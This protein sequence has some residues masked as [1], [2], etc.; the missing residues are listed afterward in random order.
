M[1]LIPLINRYAI[2]VFFVEGDYSTWPY[3]VAVNL[4]VAA[5]FGI[6]VWG[7][8]RQAGMIEAETS[9]ELRRQAFKNLQKLSY[10][11]FDQTPQGWIMARMTSDARRLSLIISWGLVDFVWA[12]LSMLFIMIVLYITF[13]KLAVIVTLVVPV[14]FVVA[15][16]FR[17]LILKQHRIARKT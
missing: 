11:Y 2:D 10:S 3:F 17:K 5:G 4:F 15:Y 13:F 9:Y 7:F 8:I 1:H 16:F 6:S 14:M 12:G